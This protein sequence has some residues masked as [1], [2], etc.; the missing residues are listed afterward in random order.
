MH[1][2]CPSILLRKSLAEKMSNVLRSNLKTI[3]Q[4]AP[5][6]T[7]TVTKPWVGSDF[8]YAQTF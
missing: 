1:F 4:A 5:I 7:S 6:N 3:L 8:S 2:G